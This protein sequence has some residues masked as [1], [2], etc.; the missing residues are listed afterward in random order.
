MLCSRRVA[1]SNR[2]MNGPV[3]FYASAAAWKNRMSKVEIGC[4]NNRDWSRRERLFQFCHSPTSTGPSALAQA[5][6]GD[7]L[8]HVKR[9]TVD[10]PVRSDSMC[11][12]GRAP[13]EH[14]RGN[15]H[16][17]DLGKCQVVIPVHKRAVWYLR[18][19]QLSRQSC[20]PRLRSMRRARAASG[21]WQESLP[22]PKGRAAAPLCLAGVIG[23]ARI[24]LNASY[25]ACGGQ[26]LCRVSHERQISVASVSTEALTFAA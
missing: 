7:C 4:T 20:S 23:R 1:A 9:D 21:C 16:A 22:T 8:D 25:E 6:L 13:T 14:A 26:T 3:H 5:P 15:P 19:C 2:R 11:A 18:R 17:L 10:G 12:M 24:E